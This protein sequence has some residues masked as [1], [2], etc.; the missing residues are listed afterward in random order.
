M[1]EIELEKITYSELLNLLKEV[2][3]F[4]KYLEKLSED[5]NNE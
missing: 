5:S 2:D 3:N 1:E 4:T